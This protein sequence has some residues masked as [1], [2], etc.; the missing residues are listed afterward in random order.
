MLYN[1]DVHRLRRADIQYT[2]PPT[3]L[4]TIGLSEIAILV[5]RLKNRFAYNT[6]ARINIVSGKHATSATSHWK[7][8]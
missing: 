7:P 8:V 3:M 1:S 6:G 2:S 4:F 5:I